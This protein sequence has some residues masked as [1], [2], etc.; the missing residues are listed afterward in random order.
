[1]L[2]K[3]PGG[4]ESDELTEGKSMIERIKNRYLYQFTPIERGD[5][6]LSQSFDAAT[7]KVSRNDE[8]K[9]IDEI[10]R[11]RDL[12]INGTIFKVGESM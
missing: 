11:M 6:D 10:V 2:K 4:E 7:E 3:G 8:S 12:N 1:M 5:I 9:S